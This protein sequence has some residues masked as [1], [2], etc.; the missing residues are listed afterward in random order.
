MEVAHTLAVV[1]AEKA[2][3]LFLRVLLDPEEHP[4]LRE[5]M[6]GDLTLW[7]ERISEE[8]LLTLLAASEPAVC[9][10]ALQAFRERPSHTTPLETV[11]SYCTHPKGYVREAAIKTLLATGLR[12]PPDPIL[13]ALNDP[14]PQVRAAASFGCISLLEWFGNQIP[15]EPLL[16]ALRDEYPAVR[17]N[18]LDALGKVPL[19][20]PV[21]PIIAVLTDA[22]PSVRCAAVETLGLMGERVPSSSY[23]LLQEMSGSPISRMQ[24]KSQLTGL[25]T[26][27]FSLLGSS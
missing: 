15:L 20:I 10:A 21:E 8:I 5:T 13:A 14:E 18:I 17:E 7:G 25:C 22:V 4:W 12:V 16:K 11:L 9:A 26:P 1:K 19:R 2:F 24:L 27:P 6:T 3:D 23:P